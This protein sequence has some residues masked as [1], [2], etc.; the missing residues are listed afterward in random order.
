MSV[1]IEAAKRLVS[2]AARSARKDANK[3]EAQAE[4]AAERARALR[5]EAKG[6]GEEAAKLEAAQ[7]V[8]EV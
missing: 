4:Q 2:S 1:R 5:A 6:F 7:E 8:L 3:V